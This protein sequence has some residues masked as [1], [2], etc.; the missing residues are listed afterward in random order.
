MID[1]Q[2]PNPPETEAAD[3]PMDGPSGLENCRARNSGFGDCVDCLSD[4]A[5]ICEYAFSFGCG[6]YCRHPKRRE[7]VL[8]TLTDSFRS[9]D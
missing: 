3:T 4:R 9:R 2:E 7:I 8:R 5:P 6:Y 1:E